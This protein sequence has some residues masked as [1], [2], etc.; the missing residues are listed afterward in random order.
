MYYISGFYKF[1]KIHGVKK[2]KKLLSDIFNKY[3]IGITYNEVFPAWTNETVTRFIAQD[4]NR[5]MD[6]LQFEMKRD[7]LDHSCL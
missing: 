6:A 5:E 7:Y 4:I 3:N 1:K 2:N